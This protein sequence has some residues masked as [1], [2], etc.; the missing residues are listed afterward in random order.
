MSMHKGE[1][2]G[3]WKMVEQDVIIMLIKVEMRPV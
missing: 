3:I 1:L 2:K